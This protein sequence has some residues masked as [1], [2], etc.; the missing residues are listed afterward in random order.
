MDE[1]Q[2]VL[3]VM[4][5]YDPEGPAQYRDGHH[6]G[7]TYRGERYRGDKDNQRSDKYRRVSYRVGDY[8]E[9]DYH[10]SYQDGRNDDRS[11]AGSRDPR[12]STDDQPLPGAPHDLT[13]EDET[14]EDLAWA[15]VL[16]TAHEK[17]SK[18]IEWI[19]RCKCSRTCEAPPTA[20]VAEEDHRRASR[21]MPR[22]HTADPPT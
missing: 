5:S 4:V 13:L 14:E 15:R 2:P 11:T 16:R 17:V 10:A 3:D 22:A 8:A 19:V 1:G 21:R 7:A 9:D 18:Q 20:P 6:W 12:A